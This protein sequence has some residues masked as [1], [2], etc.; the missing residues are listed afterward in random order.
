MAYTTFAGIPNKLAPPLTDIIPGN[1]TSSVSGSLYFQ[2]KNRQGF[3]LY[4]D[5]VS[6]NL[7]IGEGLEVTI[8]SKTSDHWDL[9]EYILS[10]SPTNSIYNSWVIATY[11]YYD[12]S[13]N[14]VPPAEKDLPTTINLDEDF[15]WQTEITIQSSDALPPSLLH[16]MRI[17]ND[18]WGEF[19]YWDNDLQEW[20]RCFPQS[21]ST[22]ISAIDGVNGFARDLQEEG[23]DPAAIIITNYT[24]SGL[25]GESVTFWLR[26]DRIGSIAKG[27]Q[28]IIQALWNGNDISHLVAGGFEATFKG[29][30]NVATGAID[31]LDADGFV[32]A[33]ANITF[34]YDFRS[35]FNLKKPLPP[36]WAY[37][38]EIAPNLSLASI[39]NSLPTNANISLLVKFGENTDAV[40][41]IST[42]EQIAIRYAIALGGD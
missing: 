7:T 2:A 36:G 17:Y 10:F 16:G 39:N 11:P 34:D 20:L 30:I 1:L 27:Q 32:M 33:G 24:L 14:S 41:D 19:R 37:V 22:Y 15:H 6:I 23:F 42:M 9:H 3:N 28:I 13:F 25:P 21:F 26:N 5:P 29:F 31:L 12:R 18:E 38:I 40:T 4:S 8:P 35:N